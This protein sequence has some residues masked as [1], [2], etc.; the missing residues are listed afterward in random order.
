MKKLALLALAGTILGLAPGLAM[1]QQRGMGGRMSPPS[2]PHPNPGGPRMNPGHGGGFNHGGNFN[3]GRNFNRNFSFNH[4]NSGQFF[5]GF[6][7]GGFFFQ[8][9]Y[10]VQNWQLYG[11]VAPQQDQRWIRYYDDAM[12]VDGRG[13]IYDARHGV[14][15]DRYGERWERDDAGIPY[16]VG[17]GDYYPDGRDY[18]RVEREGWDYS[19]YGCEDACGPAVADRR[20]EH[21]RGGHDR[22]DDDDAGYERDGDRR[23]DRDGYYAEERVR[24]RHGGPGV[25][26]APPPN[27]R[28]RVAAPPAGCGD[29][30]CGGGSYAPAPAPAPAY[31]YAPGY[32]YGGAYGYGAA[33]GAYGYGAPVIVTETTVTPITT[34]VTE[35]V[36]EEVYETGHAVRRRAA[37]RRHVAPVR[38]RAPAPAGVTPGGERG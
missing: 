1:A 3:H 30:A 8:P 15:W 35:E 5:N 17:R 34:T 26:Y 23:G 29:Y 36:I 11:F 13:Y 16:Y 14:P 19:A 38:H 33:Y 18:A 24:V 37:P 7:F 20:Y 27:V 28:V 21:G 6:G 9:Q 10:Q 12:L 32:G 25:G 2:M 4:F 22:Y 31:G